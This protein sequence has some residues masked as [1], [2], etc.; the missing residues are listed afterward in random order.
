M[1]TKATAK[2]DAFIERLRASLDPAARAE[3]GYP[4]EV[5]L[6]RSMEKV[7]MTEYPPLEGD[8]NGDRSYGDAICEDCE[9]TYW[10]HPPDWRVIGY[11][12]V[13]FL[14]VLCDGRRVKL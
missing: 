10:Q 14:N 13:P 3:F 6:R 12:N 11:G 8:H 2:I 7:G 1:G 5:I 4:E 9:C